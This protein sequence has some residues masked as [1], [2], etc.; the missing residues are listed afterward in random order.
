MQKSLHIL[1]FFPLFLGNG[2]LN[3]T[4]VCL[5]DDLLCCSN[6]IDQRYQPLRSSWGNQLVSKH[7]E[8]WLFWLLEE[9]EMYK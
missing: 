8:K 6:P 4:D 2:E 1:S 9:D 5:A 3:L 7:G